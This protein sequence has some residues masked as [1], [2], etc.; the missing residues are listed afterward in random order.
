MG[1]PVISPRCFYYVDMWSQD[2]CP[3]DELPG[4]VP[5]WF[6][7]PIFARLEGPSRSRAIVSRAIVSRASRSGGAWGAQ[8]QQQR[9]ASPS[10][11][12]R[13]PRLV[14]CPPPLATKQRDGAGFFI[15]VYTKYTLPIAS[16]P[17]R[18]CLGDRR[19]TCS[20]RPRSSRALG[21]PPNRRPRYTARGGRAKRGA[22]FHTAC[23]RKAACGDSGVQAGSKRGNL[24]DTTGKGEWQWDP[25]RWPQATARACS[26]RQQARGVEAVLAY[27][28][29]VA[30]WESIV[31]CK[32][33]DG[34]G[35]TPTLSFDEHMEAKDRL[36][37]RKALG[38]DDVPAE[39]LVTWGHVAD[40]QV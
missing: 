22:H 38:H 39:L 26:C 19:C 37:P 6:P 4:A 16:S 11:P 30:K 15:S 20:P 17:L 35:S 40:I 28:E 8:A 29:G 24:V 12:R 3:A 25:E 18:Q 13:L 23:D 1:V 14:P 7:V 2:P 32:R 34:S 10:P 36:H 21:D 27:R 31:A 5:E 33:R 9:E